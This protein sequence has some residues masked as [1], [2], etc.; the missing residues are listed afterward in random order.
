MQFSWLQN[1]AQDT[2]YG[3]RQLLRS[4][5]FALTAILTLALGIGANTAIFSLLDQALLRSLPVR[6]PQQL[7]VLEGTGK[8]WEGHSSSHGGDQE[9]YFSYPM[10]SDLRDQNKAF[11]GLIATSPSELSMT[12]H[13]A[14]EIASSEIVSGNYFT[15]LGAQA[16]KGRLL[17]QSDDGAP[18]ANPVAV[19]SYD[20]WKNHLG[21]ETNIVGQSLA[22][23]GHPFEV[24]GIAAPGFHSAVW[25]ETPKLFVPM[26][27]LEQV[28]P[29]QDKRL[30]NHKDRWL[31]ILGRLHEGESTEQAQAAMAPLWHALRAEELKALGHEPPRFV[32]EFLTNS[33]M[34]VLPGARGFSYSRDD[35]QE[36]LLVVM[37]MAILVLLISSVNVASLLLVR[38]AGR[39][40]EFSLRVALG[41][42]NGRI[43]G[44]LLLEGLM[45][46]VLGGTVGLLLAPIALR[47]L[48]HRLS[49]PGDSSYS[50]S[51]ALDTRTL[52]F[53][54]GAAVVV[55]LCFSLAPALQLR[56]PELTTTLRES[57]ST[58]SGGL[59]SL[60][61][62][63]VCLQIGLSVL[64]L[65]ASGLFVRTMQKL[66]AVD[67]GFNT[68]HIVGFGIRPNL[69]GYTPEKIPALQQHIVD[70]LSAIP[71]IEGVAATDDSLFTGSTH[72]GNISID[73]YTPAP[74][75]DIDIEKTAINPAFFSTMQ[76]PLLAGR[77]F[78]ETDGETSPKVAIVNE[79]FARHFFGSVRNALGHHLVE[80]D[81]T[82][83]VFDT[84]V[85]GVVRDYKHT[86][87]RDLPE[88]TLYRPL[89]QSPTQ[90]VRETY[91]Y[92]RTATAPADSFQAIR[93]AMQ[94]LDPTLAFDT[95]N[96]MDQQIDEALR[97]DSIVT[98]LAVSFGVLATLLAGVGL[99][100]V[101]AY[102]TAQRTKEIGI[103]I[104]LGSSRLA[105]SRI[106]LIDV[107]RLAG[108]GIAIALPL[109]YG[110]SHLL[111]SQ[112]FGVSPADP[113]TLATTI[114]LVAGVALVAALLPAYRASSTNPMDA[115]HTE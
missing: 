2:Q 58:G 70:T 12:W 29:G 73:G 7:V 56:R 95:M 86:G 22:L 72:G 45:I 90:A 96:T 50:F 13:N 32:L 43:V 78:S 8:A 61:R 108:V 71:G 36:P 59:L 16:Y 104:A 53:N 18:G 3:A 44:Q 19:L 102:S 69:A 5:G 112:L 1:V 24:I 6:D 92:L 106:V 83:L 93:H 101:L 97:D 38:S 100:G 54:F 79:S 47:V 26:S 76:V 9:A 84:E 37:G 94:Q 91:L 42:R 82:K 65:V 31:N 25:G 68:N 89:K 66:R 21:A 34:L 15:V 74:D 115:L 57:S 11:Q 14:A 81:P 63:I 48:V 23:N 28:I 62:V 46:G 33:R 30:S 87:I 113:V 105:I 27:M 77:T 80:G 110:L 10:Y 41:A 51:S 103:R 109:A 85:I 20:F 39:V 98:L 40:R 52:L 64:L 67:V 88:P 35:L 99:Y 111:R 114:L 55:S 4:P 107:L 49:G 60:R 75:E 17:T